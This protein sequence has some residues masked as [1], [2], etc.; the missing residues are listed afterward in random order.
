MEGHAVG[1]DVG[2]DAV[3][4][5]PTQ[6][7]LELFTRPL[8]NHTQRGELVFDPFAGSGTCLIAAEQSGRRCI[9]VE[10]DAAWCD[11]IRERYE[12]LQTVGRS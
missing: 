4:A 7:P 11:V 2:E 12:R 3:T 1:G 10:L 6:K 9:T 8:L 5:H